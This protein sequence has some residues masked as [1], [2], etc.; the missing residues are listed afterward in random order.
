MC[1]WMGGGGGGGR[2]A[3]KSGARYADGLDPGLLLSIT[4]RFCDVQK[5]K[6]IL[7]YFYFKN[8]TAFISFNAR[9]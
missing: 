7:C 2:Q 9:A 1:V 6:Y 4:A 8:E 5:E 3:T